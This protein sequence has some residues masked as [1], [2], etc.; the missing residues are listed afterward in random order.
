MS[1]FMRK[2]EFV[3]LQSDV[4]SLPAMNEVLPARQVRERAIQR[5]EMLRLSAGINRRFPCNL[6][7]SRC[8]SQFAG[9]DGLASDCQHSHPAAVSFSKIPSGL[10]SG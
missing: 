10:D 4:R 5:I 6:A 2:A 3:E 8:I 9:R 1:A 7:Q